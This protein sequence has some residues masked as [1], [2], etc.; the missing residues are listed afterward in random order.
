[1]NSNAATVASVTGDSTKKSVSY[2][3][4]CSK[5]VVESVNI[6]GVRV[7]VAGTKASE[8]D[9]NIYAAGTTYKIVSSNWVRVKDSYAMGASDVFEDN[10]EYYLKVIVEPAAGYSINNTTKL[11]FNGGESVANSSLS[12]IVGD[13]L[14]ACS[15]SWELAGKYTVSFNMNGQG[16]APA[17]QTIESG[18][19]AT[20]P[21]VTPTAT[22][23]TFDG[24]YKDAACTTEFDFNSAITTDTVVYAKWTKNAVNYTVTFNMN[25][26]GI[27][28]ASQT[29]DSGNKAKMPGGIPTTEGYTF[30]GWY[31]DAEG[32][33]EFDFNTAITKDTV[34]Y[35]KW[36]KNSNNYSVT[37][38]MNGHGTKVE[39]QTVKEGEKAV[40]PADPAATGYT[41]KGWF[42]D[43]A[44]KTEF[45]FNTPINANTTIYA[46]WEEN[47]AEQPGGDT[48]E[49]GGDVTWTSDENS[50]WHA[51]TCGDTGDVI[52]KAAHTWDAGKVT[53][54]ATLDSTGVMTYTCSVCKAVKTVEIPKLTPTVAPTPTPEPTVIITPQETQETTE[55]Q[56]TAESQETAESADTPGAEDG[57][58]PETE[59]D[60]ADGRTS[61]TEEGEKAATVE[62][63]KSDLAEVFTENKVA[64]TEQGI[65]SAVPATKKDSAYY[66]ESGRKITNSFIRTSDNKYRYVGTTG[67]SVKKAVVATVDAATGEMKMYYADKTG[68]IVRNKVVTLPD[69]GK[70]FASKDGTLATNEIVTSGKHQYYAGSNG[71][72]LKNKI[73]RLKDGTRYYANRY[74]YIRKNALFTAPDGD[75]RYATAD[76]TLAKNCWVTVGKKMYWCNKIGRITKS[77]PVEGN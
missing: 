15:V 45:D 59:K 54:E 33:V 64:V 71:K 11:M 35:A 31:A 75:K 23:Y 36:I 68:V 63:V 13:Q 60:E 43:T 17:S 74:G 5:A 62:T 7:P 27:A 46:K 25:G 73:I 6:M 41:F 16:T 2:S 10:Q 1:M 51:A 26:H 29:V 22:G 20:K 66:D 53:K 19:K 3:F 77:K 49:P 40:K 39:A 4:T 38:N 24:W 47:A 50:H 52:D 12:K 69:G 44:L 48:T 34:I 8:Y 61:E 18:K 32:T 14:Q 42:A 67:K 70:I 28:P 65:E 55:T 57:K 37:F 56:G 21:S 58:V 72:F 30:I 76:G 9:N